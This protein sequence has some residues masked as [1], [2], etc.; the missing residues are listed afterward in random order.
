MTA[1]VVRAVYQKNEGS[2]IMK[3]GVLVESFRK[4]FKAS[5]KAAAAVGVNGI[6]AYAHGESVNADLTPVQV[7]G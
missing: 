1:F 4:D 7:R 2:I 3:I 6:Q 5:L